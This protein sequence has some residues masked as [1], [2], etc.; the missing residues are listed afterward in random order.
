[1]HKEEHGVG[2]ANN[3]NALLLE[4]R[5][6]LSDTEVNRICDTVRE[7]AFGL[8]RYLGSGFREKVYERGL[9]HRCRKAGLDVQVQPRVK[10]FIPCFHRSFCVP[11]ALSW[12]ILRK[13]ASKVQPF[14]PRRP[15]AQTARCNTQVRRSKSVWL[16]V[17]KRSMRWTGR[18]FAVGRSTAYGFRDRLSDDR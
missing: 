17:Q 5:T 4:P 18:K 6:D 8:Y 3:G 10:I 12:L 16:P 15:R 2:F 1:M 14:A 11:C 13:V 9:V 7:A